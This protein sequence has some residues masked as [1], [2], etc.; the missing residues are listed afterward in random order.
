MITLGDKSLFNI[1]TASID[2]LNASWYCDL[3][4]QYKANSEYWAGK[5]TQ[6]V[7]IGF[8]KLMALVSALLYFVWQVDNIDDFD[9]CEA[10]GGTVNVY[11]DSDVQGA[12]VTGDDIAVK[13]IGNHNIVLL[14]NLSKFFSDIPKNHVSNA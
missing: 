5:F 1:L 14:S 3:V 11:S 10:A 9:A 12:L 8:F 13:V 2:Q 6:A 7:V 4:K